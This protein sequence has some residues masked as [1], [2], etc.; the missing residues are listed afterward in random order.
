MQ[1]LKADNYKRVRLPDAEPGQ[2]F[3]YENEG[4]VLKLT[5]VTTADEAV[6]VVKLVRRP[7][8]TYS[9]PKGVKIS[10]AD[11]RAAIRADRDSQ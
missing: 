11:I 10:R 5:L 9:F 7:D 1:T 6:P 4:N 8:G 3:A 2:M